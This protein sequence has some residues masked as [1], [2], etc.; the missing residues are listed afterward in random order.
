MSAATHKVTVPAGF[1]MDHAERFENHPDLCRALSVRGNY[2]RIECTP[3][4]LAFLK[5]DATFYADPKATDAPV[6][7]RRSASA[8]LFCL[9]A[10]VAQ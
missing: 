8:T 7:L 5:A 3:A 4:Q 9:G 6:W 2:A 1:W 10:G